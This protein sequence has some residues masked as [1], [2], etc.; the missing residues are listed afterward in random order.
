MVSARFAGRF[1]GRTGERKLGDNMNAK[2][3]IIPGLCWALWSPSKRQMR[4]YLT[5]AAALEVLE[6]LPGDWCL[7]EFFD[8]RI[9]RGTISKHD[10]GAMARLRA[11]AS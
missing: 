9:S 1:T 2:N 3:E 10:S 11:I 7:E 4:V 5:P 6:G 8:G